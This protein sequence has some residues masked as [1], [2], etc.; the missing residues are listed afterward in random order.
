MSAFDTAPL[1]VTPARHQSQDIPF[2]EWVTLLTLCLAPLIAHVVVGTPSP[3]YLC[4]SRPKWHERICHYNPTS[5]LWRYAA[6]TDRRIRARSW[7]R[8]DLAATNALFWTPRGWDG[9][10]AMSNSLLYCTH[11]PEHSRVSVFSRETIKTLIVTFQ[12]IQAIVLLS[13]V[14]VAG[15]DVH[16]TIWMAVDIIFFPLA[17]IGLLRLCCALWLNED[18]SYSHS[19]AVPLNP[20]SAGSDRGRSSFDSLLEISAMPQQGQFRD[21]SFWPS[22]LFRAV[23]LLYTLGM[24]T[25][26]VLFLVRGG[27]HIATS[28]VVMLFFLLHVAATTFILMFYFFRGLTTTTLIPCIT[29]TLYKLYTAILIGLAVAVIVVACVETRRTPCGKYTSG[30]GALADLISCRGSAT[31][32][33]ARQHSTVVSL[34]MHYAQNDIIPRNFEVGLKDG[35]NYDRDP[36]DGV[37]KFEARILIYLI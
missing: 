32:A 20:R 11:L 22:R 25:F 36:P 6:I 31:K 7:N 35:K 12:G 37:L 23:F 17:L 13:G 3:S 28:F 10:E 8:A 4:T 16:F 14:F 5:I 19:Y 18:F 30:Y 26:A 2:S 21:R 24:P 29:A 27:Q 9:S 1:V 15:S 33:L 34:L